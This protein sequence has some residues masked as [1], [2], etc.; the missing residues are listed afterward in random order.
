MFLRKYVQGDATV[1]DK[2][3]NYSDKNDD[4]Y[5]NIKWLTLI[6]PVLCVGIYEFVRFLFLDNYFSSFTNGMILMI[7]VGLFGSFFSKWLFKKIQ[8]IHDSLFWEQ[9]RLQTIFDYTSDGIIVINEDCR[10]LDIN[11]AAEKLTGW[12]KKEV[13]GNVTCDKMIGCT[14]NKEACW[15]SDNPDSCMNVDCGHR[16]CWGRTAMEKK[17]SIP[18][19]EMCIRKKNGQKLKVAASYSY[20]PPVG[21][22]KS[23]IKIVLRDISERKEFEIAIQNYATL[24]ERY[25]LAREMHDGLAQ[26]MV[27]INF[28][29]QSIQRSL[30]ET[31]CSQE[32]LNEVVDLRQV[33]Q[34]AVNEVRQ[35]IYDLKVPP[36][37]ETSCFRV[38]IEDYLKYFGNVNHLETE[39][40]CN[41]PQSLILP[42]EVKVQLIR[43][44]QEALSNIKKHAFATK[45]NIFLEKS[46]KKI[47]ISITDN[48]RGINVDTSDLGKYHFGLA[49]MHE[50]ARIIG[51]KT[52]IGPNNP[53][54]TLVEITIPR[55]YSPERD[56]VVS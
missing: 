19:V 52:K 11:P 29:A 38:W 36:R 16:E 35:N 41:C 26:N 6:I 48:G 7:A 25:R 24:E 46:P 21:E 50:R 34:E 39:F 44:I 12:D 3:D 9:Q 1:I 54:G 18:N 42:T 45:V 10:I 56:S 8:R 43:I 53:Q 55:N 31:A 22:E 32:V 37:K 5:V 13:I 49:I 17:V 40:T 33:I 20:I 15:N 51:G 30:E 47:T 4:Y 14:A 27:Y 28:K 2:N 23:Q